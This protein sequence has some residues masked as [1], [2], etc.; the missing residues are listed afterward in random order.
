LTTLAACQPPPVAD[1][2]FQAFGTSV[3][4]EILSAEPGS[5]A[6]AAAAR[7]IESRFQ[8]ANTDWYAFGT[9][10]LATVNALLA[11]GQ[12]APVSAD[13]APLIGRAIAL[14]EQSGGL[15]DPG[16]CALVRLWQFDNA[17]DLAAA[18]GPPPDEARRALRAS[19]GTLA[20]LR[21]DGHTASSS[22][23]LCIDLG[24]MAKGTAL[25]QARA[26]LAQHG[27]RN[28]LIDIGGSSQLAIGRKGA[29]P[30]VIGLK[31]PR[32]NRVI[33]RLSLRPGEAASTSGDYER[34]YTRAGRR[35]HHI[36]DPDTGAPT[37]GSASV[38][39]LAMDGELVDAA[40]TALMV[41][42]PTRF[43][44]ISAALGIVDALLI[45]TS[46][47][48]LTTPGMAARLRRDNNGR[49]PD[50]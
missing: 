18:S 4:I 17:E 33:A 34:G 29:S 39:A 7:D 27:I 9:G 23:P 37:T 5:A 12:A 43:R 25:E 36:L 22:R 26:V 1:H 13:L 31:D 44:D 40:T 38:T 2:R 47:E 42:G 41:A 15:F 50:L 10:E 14:H 16:V 49:L 28:A 45:T 46:G 30:W 8:K 24:G 11:R 6:A 21:F 19:Q 20:D 32:A 35:Y 48:L 3:R